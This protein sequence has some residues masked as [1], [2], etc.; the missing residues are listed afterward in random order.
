[1]RDFQAQTEVPARGLAHL[2]RQVEKW[3]N[4]S[5]QA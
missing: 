1:M 5:T 4:V 3:V 2:C